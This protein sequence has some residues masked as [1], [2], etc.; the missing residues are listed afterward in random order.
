MSQTTKPNLI[1][2][3]L[4]VLCGA[5]ALGLLLGVSGSESARW[6]AAALGAL[7]GVFLCTHLIAWR[8]VRQARDLQRKNVATQGGNLPPVSNAT[9]KKDDDQRKL[10]ISRLQV[11][12]FVSAA[13][14]A[15]QR[16]L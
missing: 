2:L 8:G 1:Y 9:G 11:L 3:V 5:L 7:A 13:A 6:A 16:L 10:H 14:A 12:A 15:C 4:T